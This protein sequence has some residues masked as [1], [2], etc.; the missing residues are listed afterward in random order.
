VTTD[1]DRRRGGGPGNGCRGNR[2]RRRAQSNLA[3][4]AVALVVVTTVTVGGVVVAEEALSS[5][6]RDAAARRA[7]GAVADRL[8]APASPTT[9]RANV[10]DT[11]AITDEDPDSPAAL[12]SAAD[13]PVRV[14]LGN[15]TLVDRG[16]PSGP[17]V[18]R[19]V[20]VGER[21]PERTRVA[22]GGNRTVVVN[23]TTRIDLA[24]RLRPGTVVRTVRADGR[25]V[26]HAP[27]GLDGNATLEPGGTGPTRLRFVGNGTN[28]TVVVTTYPLDTEPGVLAVTVGRLRR[29]DGGDPTD[30]GDTAAEGGDDADDSGGR[31]DDRDGD[32]SVD[33]RGSDG[34]VEGSR[35]PAGDP[36]ADE[37]AWPGTGSRT[38]GEASLVG[39]NVQSGREGAA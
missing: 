4:L 10:L 19:A 11:A 34:S 27:S 30:D 5:V 37:T 7:A 22:L 23:R 3:A 13:R 28:G 8:V 39:S 18:R 33:E 26:L 20:L 29:T 38:A 15:R 12:T 6:D 31:E 24:F 16:S 17:T 35:G 9:H 36:D 25:P 2:G 32:R 1:R 14:R 21:R